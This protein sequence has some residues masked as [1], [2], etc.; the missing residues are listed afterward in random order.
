MISH[1]ICLLQHKINDKMDT[2]VEHAYLVIA[3]GVKANPVYR[4]RLY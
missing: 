3:R 2:D 1:F 4:Y